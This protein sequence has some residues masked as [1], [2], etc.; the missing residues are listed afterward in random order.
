MLQVGMRSSTLSE[1]SNPPEHRAIKISNI[2][3]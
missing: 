3:L 1:K 2:N